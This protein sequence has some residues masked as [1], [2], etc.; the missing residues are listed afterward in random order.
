MSSALKKIQARVKQ[1]RKKH[2][3]AKFRSLQKQAGS[4]Y[5]SGKLGGVKKK[6]R[7]VAK[8]KSAPRKRITRRRVGSTN[9]SSRDAVDR[10]K[11]DITI[12]SSTTAVSKLKKKLAEEIGWK[13][14]AKLTAQTAKS[15]RNIEKQIREKKSLY[16]KLA[17]TKKRRRR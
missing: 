7:T 17:G 14:A 6:K 13:E 5:R 8:K 12:G 4:E 1:L 3:N 11:V 16:N 10:K 9:K 2:P 15:K